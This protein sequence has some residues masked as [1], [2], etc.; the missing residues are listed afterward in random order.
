MTKTAM[1]D[2]MQVVLY[3]AKAVTDLYSEAGE[4]VSAQS[5]FPEDRQGPLKC[6]WVR[7]AQAKRHPGPFDTFNKNLSCF[8]NPVTLGDPAGS[9]G[10]EETQYTGR[11]THSGESAHECN[12]PTPFPYRTAQT[13]GVQ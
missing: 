13:P 11:D 1:C 6:Q 10:G 4:N 5:S 2:T 12:L 8:Q 9:L 7:T 3:P